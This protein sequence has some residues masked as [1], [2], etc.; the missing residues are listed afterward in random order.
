MEIFVIHILV[1]QRNQPFI[2]VTASAQA[3]RYI[4]V[5]AVF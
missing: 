1:A 5:T 2:E 4:P 3:P